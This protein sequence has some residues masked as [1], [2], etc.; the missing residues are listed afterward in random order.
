MRIVAT[1]ALIAAG[2][3]SVTTSVAGR[4]RRDPVPPAVPSGPAR[5]CIALRSI[6]ESRVYDDRTIDFF[7]RPGRRSAYRVVLPQ[8]CPGLGFEQSFA[9][10]TS[11]SELCSTDIITVLHSSSHPLRGASCG[12]APFQPVM[13]AGRR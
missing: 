3:V 9:Y 5:N 12:L 13:L 1:L 7:T 6:E 2:A 11:L 8:D 4:D 10:E